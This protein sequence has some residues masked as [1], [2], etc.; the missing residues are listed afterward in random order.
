MSR[1][2]A[3]PVV[4]A[5]GW[6]VLVTVQNWNGWAMDATALYMAGKSY[7]AEIWSLVY[8]DTPLTF[9]KEAPEQWAAW[10]PEGTWD[11][12][13]FTPFL[14]PPIW[15]ALMAGL[16]E[17]I[18][19]VTFFRLV[20][21]TNVAATLAMIWMLWK[22]VAPR[23]MDAT[24]WTLLS[25]IFLTISASGIASYQLGQLQPMVYAMV[26]GAMLAL[27]RGRD[28]TA[29][30]L[31]ALAA[32]IK[33]TPALFVVILVMEKRWRALMAFALVGGGLGALS[34]LIA[35]WPLHAA[36]LNKISVLDA[37]T[38]FAP[39][40]I[41]LELCLTQISEMVRGVA[42]QDFSDPRSIPDLPW[43]TWV[44]RATLVA[45]LVAIWAATRSLSEPPR[46]WL[47]LLAMVLL[48]TVT[49]PL[50]WV[51]YMLLPMLMLPALAEI[52][53]RRVAMIAILFTAAVFSDHVL[54][55]LLGGPKGD[56]TLI[57]L[58]LGT[59]LALF[60]G[61]LVRGRQLSAPKGLP[62][63]AQSL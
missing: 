19:L 17:V 49:G 45:G 47:R 42:V 10:R 14:Y 53:P 11:H 57:F 12:P 20:L 33:L 13:D 55:W 54:T 28:V 39:I 2:V 62:P 34:I 44:V 8:D 43:V 22:L 18:S 29:G 35:G 60:I 63:R 26:V 30:G 1:S 46:L 21:L 15:A 31:L 24:L 52:L 36:F 40:L 3:L 51:H 9:Y 50:G 6:A 61:L 37:H 25:V 38:L 23:Q 32:A 7:G 59:A 16:S 48:T 58:S 5:L 4:I 27:S 41:S 56:V